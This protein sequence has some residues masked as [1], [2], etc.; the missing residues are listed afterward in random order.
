MFCFVGCEEDSV[1]ANGVVE[2]EKYI[3]IFETNG[4][5]SVERKKIDVI[6]ASPVTTRSG[7]DFCGWYYDSDLT[8]KV[9]FPVMLSS[10][11]TF[12]AKWEK[13][14]YNVSFITN[15]GTQVQSVKTDKIV[16]L[17]VTSK[18][19]YDFCGWYYDSNLTQKAAFPLTLKSD[20]ILYAKWEK[21][22]YV[23]KFI[24]NGGT[25]VV[26]VKTSELKA[27]PFTLKSGYNFV[28]WYT[29]SKF[30]Q[31]VTFPVSINAPTTFYA[32]WLPQEYN[33]RCEDSK[34]KFMGL[35]YDIT[36]S[37]FDFEDMARLGYGMKITVTYDVYYKKDYDVWLDLGYMG[38]PKYEVSIQNSNEEGT[39]YEDLGTTLQG[40][41][42]SVSV[43]YNSNNLID[44]NIILKFSSDNI[45]NIIYFENISVKYECVK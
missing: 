36:P 37:V 15:G 31:K 42:R 30:T 14:V 45:Q 4:G 24:A 28:G 20:L 10:D 39:Y 34:I 19:G 33:M 2:D 6:Q 35:T 41:T 23:V 16:S 11:F 43:K 22:P 8:T 5:S 1:Q 27:S 21:T 26:N 29:D 44:S 7:Y 9:N 17:P 13:I 3:A 12:Y 18:A 38:S 25:D 32:K 40:D